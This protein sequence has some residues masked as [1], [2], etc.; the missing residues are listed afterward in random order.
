MAKQLGADLFGAADLTPARS[1]ICSQGGEYLGQFPRAISVGIRLLDA[2][3]DELSRHEERSPIFSYRGLF[4]S[5]NSHL[6]HIALLLAKEI[7]RNGYRAYPI[8]ASQFVDRTTL[9]GAFSHKLAAH[10][11]GLGWIGK[12]ALLVT[13]VHGP[14]VRFATV[15]TDM[16]LGT[17]S[18]LNEKCGDCKACVEICPVK[19]FTG[20][21]FDPSEPREARFNAHSCDDYSKKRQ[22]RLGES[23]CGLCVYVCPYGRSQEH[24]VQKPVEGRPAGN[25]LNK[26]EI[27]STSLEAGAKP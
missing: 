21:P 16:P 26:T 19:A 9:T 11:A 14:R 10:L 6:D 2:V 20:A 27:P 1:F 4:T 15:L 23:L 17:G 5:V 22:E 24:H 8:P 13:P 18:Q 12:S 3:V 25:N 7:E